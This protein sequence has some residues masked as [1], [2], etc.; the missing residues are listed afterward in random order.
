[1]PISDGRFTSE[2]AGG[3]G[4]CGDAGGAPGGG[5]ADPAPRRG[6]DVPADVAA[7]IGRVA[8]DGAAKALAEVEASRRRGRYL[9]RGIAAAGD[10]RLRPVRLCASLH[11][12]APR[13]VG[14]LAPTA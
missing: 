1:M 3:R 9:R 10:A 12:H 7:M 13:S 4:R 2:R 11:N 8:Q 14:L 6:G 5:A